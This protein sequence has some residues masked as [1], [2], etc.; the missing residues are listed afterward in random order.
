MR[1]SSKIH[2]ARS[3]RR[4][5]T[6]PWI[7][8]IGP[9]STIF[10]KARRCSSFNLEELPGALP[11]TSPSGPRLLKR[12]TQSQMICTVTLPILAASVREPPS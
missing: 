3:L 5:R 7:A 9:L 10:A 8:G 12:T 2:R 11:L 1:N 6:T 4:Q